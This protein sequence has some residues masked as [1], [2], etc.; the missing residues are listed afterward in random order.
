MFV[1]SFCGLLALWS[2]V[3]E[4]RVGSGKL[5]L[6]LYDDDSGFFS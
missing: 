6:L 2:A 3:G 5:C 1:V 4:S